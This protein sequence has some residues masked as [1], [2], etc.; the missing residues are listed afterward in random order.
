MQTTAWTVLLIL[1]TLW[2]GLGA[3]H[4]SLKPE[5]SASSLVP[6]D[7][8]ASP[9]FRTLSDSI[10]FLGGLNFGFM[11]LCAMLLVFADL[12]PHALQQAFFAAVIAVAHA[13]QF[14]ANVPMI[15]KW[16]RNAPGAWRVLEGP[17]LF[18]FA[19]DGALMLANA[20]FA[21][22]VAMR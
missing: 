21:A 9:L 10:R 20:A 14:A 6:R 19:T 3:F 2:F 12:F 8:R 7:Q 5:A 4:F 11:V 15:G 13:S 17:M 16:R 22:W 1:N 18:I